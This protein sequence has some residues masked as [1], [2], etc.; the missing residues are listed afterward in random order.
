MGYDLLPM[1]S[2]AGSTWAPRRRR[3][4]Q[5]GPPGQPARAWFHPCHAHHAGAR[6]SADAADS[7]AT[8][9]TTAGPGA[10]G[11]E[12]RNTD[13]PP[14]PGKEEAEGRGDAR[15]RGPPAAPPL[16]LPSAEAGGG[17]TYY[18]ES[19]MLNASPRLFR[20]PDSRPEFFS[21]SFPKITRRREPREVPGPV[22]VYSQFVG[23]GGLAGVAGTSGSPATPKQGAPPEGR[24][25][26]AG[27]SGAAGALGAAAPAGEAGPGAAFCGCCWG[28]RAR[29]GPCRHLHLARL[30]RGAP[31]PGFSAALRR[32]GPPPRAGTPY[33]DL[34]APIHEV[35][36]R[37]RGATSPGGA[38]DYPRVDAV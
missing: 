29:A 27:R 3:R 6:S 17:N 37:H 20:R 8:P 38:D 21:R 34:D 23:A 14:R 31:R 11:N 4:A 24:A 19:R 1:R 28:N 33:V 7:R 26:G 15:G 13:V 16:A 12:R 2:S 25:T 9:R 18:V 36:Y 5:P 32:S 10:G 30:G 22:A 35:A